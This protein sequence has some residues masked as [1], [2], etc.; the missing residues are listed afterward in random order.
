PVGERRRGKLS[1][2]KI[3]ACVCCPGR[4]VAQRPSRLVRKQRPRQHFGIRTGRQRS[5]RSSFRTRGE[6]NQTFGFGPPPSTARPVCQ[7]S[8]PRS[9]FTLLTPFAG[10]L[11]P[12][13]R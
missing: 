3:L 13:M 1:S 6:R 11:V 2:R 9:P 10:C 4:C 5:R 8:I 7:R 12:H